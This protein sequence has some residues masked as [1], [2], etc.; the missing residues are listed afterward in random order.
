M[1]SF[2]KTL[3]FGVISVGIL[4]L[5]ACASVSRPEGVTAADVPTGASKFATSLKI[6]VIETFED[7]TAKTPA[8]DLE[9]YQTIAITALNQK[10]SQE[11]LE[12]VAENADAPLKA[13]ID[14]TVRKW[15]PLT[16]GS[17]VLKATVSNSVGKTLYSAEAA[18]VLHL[19]ANGFDTKVALKTASER[20][21]SGL[22]DGLK[23][24]RA[25]AS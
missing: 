14:V 22:I 4:A 23:P 9:A 21:A 2:A 20:L 10:L 8:A 6:E 12:V 18:E 17:T 11:K 5:A 3:Q 13:R 24:L 7:V 15:N 1:R 25:P 16:G 19:I